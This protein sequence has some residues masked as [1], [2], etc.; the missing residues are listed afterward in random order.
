MI[1]QDRNI[2]TLMNE[3]AHASSLRRMQRGIYLQGIEPIDLKNK[4]RE[5]QKVH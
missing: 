4:E 5:N 2:M 3:L 1:Q